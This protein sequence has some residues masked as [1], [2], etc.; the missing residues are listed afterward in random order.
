MVIDQRLSSG[1]QPIRV[2]TDWL[3]SDAAGEYISTLWRCTMARSVR[4]RWIIPA[5]LLALGSVVVGGSAATGATPGEQA[6][7]TAPIPVLTGYGTQPC[8]GVSPCETPVGA[9]V[10]MAVPLIKTW[11]RGNDGGWSQFTLCCTGI[12]LPGAGTV[13]GLLNGHPATVV[14]SGGTSRSGDL[15]GAASASVVYGVSGASYRYARF[16]SAVSR[17]LEDATDPDGSALIW[18]V[19]S[20]VWSW[21]SCRQRGATRVPATDCGNG[22]QQFTRGLSRTPR[23]ANPQSYTVAL[24]I[25]YWARVVD[26]RGRPLANPY[27]TSTGHWIL[28][29][30][31]AY[32][33]WLWTVEWTVGN[34]GVGRVAAS[35]YISGDRIVLTTGPFN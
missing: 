3:S 15:T 6:A 31:A 12:N 34:V 18:T 35:S 9:G 2:I 1:R 25:N 11:L 5:V 27:R 21:S 8:F 14:P 28:R 30:Q 29:T 33:G 4:V 23:P 10:G 13:T 17:T 24:P 32:H 7:Q 16:A 20:D 22:I 26:S 19:S